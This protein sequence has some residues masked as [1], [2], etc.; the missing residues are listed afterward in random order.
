MLVEA[1]KPVGAVSRK[2]VVIRIQRFLTGC[3]GSGEGG[4]VNWL[5]FAAI[6]AGNEVLGGV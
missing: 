5:E 3:V 4:G 2:E 6:A 1:G